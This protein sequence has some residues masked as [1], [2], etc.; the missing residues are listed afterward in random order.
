MVESL[1]KITP[2]TLHGMYTML[3]HHEVVCGAQVVMV[4][5]VKAAATCGET[6]TPH[7]GVS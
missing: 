4:D 3:R 6:I 7:Q 1:Q 5:T 2:K